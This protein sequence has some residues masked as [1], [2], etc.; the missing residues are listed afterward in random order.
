[1][2]SGQGYRYLA[3]TARPTRGISTVIRVATLVEKRLLG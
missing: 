1:M 2:P 3:S